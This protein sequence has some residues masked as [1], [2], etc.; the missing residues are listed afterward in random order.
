MASSKRVSSWFYIELGKRVGP[1]S[2]K[3]LLEIVKSG[4]IPSQTL[5]WSHGMKGWIPFSKVF[6]PDPVAI[7]ETAPPSASELQKAKKLEAECKGKPPDSQ[8]DITCGVCHQSWL[9]QYVMVIRSKWV[10]VRCKDIMDREALKGFD[11]DKLARKVSD[12]NPALFAVMLVAA[13]LLIFSLWF[14]VWPNLKRFATGQSPGSETAESPSEVQLWLSDIKKLKGDGTPWSKQPPETW[15]TMVVTHNANISD[16]HQVKGGHG[17]LVQGRNQL[18][19]LTSNSIFES[20]ISQHLLANPTLPD[21]LF[22]RWMIGSTLKPDDSL[23]LKN[24]AGFPGD[25]KERDTMVFGVNAPKHRD[26]GP[27]QSLVPRLTPLME[28]E[29]VYIVHNEKQTGET[30]GVVPAEVAAIL[31]NGTQIEAVCQHSYLPRAMLGAPI[32][33]ADGYLVGVVTARPDADLDSASSWIT[34]E[35]IVGIIPILEVA[36]LAATTSSAP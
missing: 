34:G 31:A 26:Q 15:P 13:A 16:Q 1:A 22:E 8:P 12:T 21:A 24:R 25:Y 11:P 17:S 9:S 6:P 32:I 2:E 33:D 20:N 4:T 23:I 5:I 36:D 19:L 3:K 28:A 14:Q 30:Q 35:T 27:A 7:G 18:F 29:P 10:C